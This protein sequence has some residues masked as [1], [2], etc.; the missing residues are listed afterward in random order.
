MDERIGEFPDIDGLGAEVEIEFFP[1]SFPVRWDQ[2]GA[3]ADFFASYFSRMPGSG[4]DDDAVQAEVSNAIS[5]VLN[6]V[7]ENA[8]KFQRGGTISVRVGTFDG[9]L[10]FVVGNWIDRTALEALRPRLRA[11]VEGDAQEMLLQRVEENAANPESGV[12]GLG[13]LTMITDYDARLGWRITA[14]EGA[15]D[16][17]HLATMARLPIHRT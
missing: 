16:R 6:E 11:L 13:F 7:V 5:Y 17:V 10:I 15:G 14:P 9:D 3:T 1:T 12:S 4:G 2:C 8:V